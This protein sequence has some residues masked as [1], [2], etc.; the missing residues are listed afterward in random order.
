MEDEIEHTKS[1][2]QQPQNSFHFIQA[3]SNFR[4]FI[5]DKSLSNFSSYLEIHKPDGEPATSCNLKQLQNQQLLFKNYLLHLKYQQHQ[6]ML[7]KTESSKSL[8]RCHTNSTANHVQAAIST[9]LSL[10]DNQVTKLGSEEPCQKDHLASR[11]SKMSD[12]STGGMIKKE[13]CKN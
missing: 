2:E 11:K 4:N 12:G 5:K 9:T 7:P 6:L 8:A 3:F 1:Q 10:C 13:T